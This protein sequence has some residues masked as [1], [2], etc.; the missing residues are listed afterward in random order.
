MRL[1]ALRENSQSGLPVVASAA[2]KAPLFSPRAESAFRRA[3]EI[4]PDLNLAHHLS[5]YLEVDLGRAPQAM[6]RLLER[7]RLHGNDPNLFAG[8]VHVAGTAGYWMLPLPPITKPAGSTLSFRR[9][10]ITPSSWLATTCGP[11]R[12]LM[13]RREAGSCC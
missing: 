11:A 4:N 10:C 2:M 7:A 6:V 9:V 12:L 8:L 13:T 1:G 3:M 5:A